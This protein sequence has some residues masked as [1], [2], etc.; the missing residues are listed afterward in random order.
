[1][2]FQFCVGTQACHGIRADMLG[3][4]LQHGVLAWRERQRLC[5]AHADDLDVMGGIL[6]RCDGRLNDAC[7]MRD[8]L[9]WFRDFD[10]TALGQDAGAGEHVLTLAGVGD[11]GFAACL[12]QAAT[13][14]F[15]AAGTTTAGHAAIGNRH[16][17][18]AQGVEQICT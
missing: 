9:V 14:D 4:E 10:G 5:R 6:D 18:G 7:G 16:I 17:I 11:L 3:R 13:D 12:Q 2:K 8:D 15:A 1:M